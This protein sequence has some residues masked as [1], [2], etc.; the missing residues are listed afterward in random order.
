MLQFLNFLQARVREL[1][2]TEQHSSYTT[3]ILLVGIPN[4]GKSALA[5]SLHQI[6]RISAAGT[7]SSSSGLKIY[8]LFLSLF[9]HFD[10]NLSD[11][12]MLIE[13]LILCSENN[14]CVYIYFKLLERFLLCREGKVEAC[15]SESTTWRDKRHKQLEG[16]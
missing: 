15:Y 6:G 14:M 13:S 16:V 9:F 8:C 1:K 5:N 7:T 3:T 2:K 11:I 4:V 10:G 12:I